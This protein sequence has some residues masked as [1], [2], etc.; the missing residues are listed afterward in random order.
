MSPS[1]VVAEEGWNILPFYLT[2]IK[3]FVS[4][5]ITLRYSQWMHHQSC[6]KMVQNVRNFV[7]PCRNEIEQWEKTILRVCSQASTKYWWWRHYCSQR[8]K[9]SW[10]PIEQLLRYFKP[11]TSWWCKEDQSRDQHQISPLGNINIQNHPI[12]VKLF[13][14]PQK[15]LML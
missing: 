6:I 14:S 2:A 4:L 9:N 15:S 7:M 11:Q 3:S 13:R 1:F 12:A 5:A 10:Q 8:P